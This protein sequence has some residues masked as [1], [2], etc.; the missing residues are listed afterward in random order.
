AQLR[1]LLAPGF[2]SAIDDAIINL[3]NTTVR[4]IILNGSPDLG[5]PPLDPLKI[6]HLDLDINLDGTAQLKGVLDGVEVRKI[7]TFE[8]D[9]V[10]A[11]LLLLRAD[12]GISVPE[13]V[14]AGEHYSLDGN[15]GGLLP[16][17]GEGPF[18]ASV[19]GVNLTGSVTLGGNSSIIYVKYLEL[20]I[21]VKAAKVN[22]EGLLGGGDLGDLANEIVSELIPDLVTELKPTVLP[23]IIA[24]VIDLANEKLKDITLQDILDLINGG[25]LKK[26]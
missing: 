8:V 19:E 15:L 9:L 1:T 7:A 13:I 6:D 24:A 11:N 16:V 14:A 23:D 12:F 4:D 22:F 21:S 2:K 20:D 5:I 17:Y 18:A 26:L 25:G 3:L 10:S